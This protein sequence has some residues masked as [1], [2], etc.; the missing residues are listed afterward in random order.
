AEDGEIY[1]ENEIKRIGKRACE[2]A[3]NRNKKL[4]GV[5]KAN[6][7]ES[8]ILWRSIMEDLAKEFEDVELSHMYVDKAAMQ[9]VKDPSQFDVIVTNNIFGDIISDEAAMITG[10][11]G[12]L[13]SASLREAS[14][15]M[16]ERIHGSAPDIAG[17][18]IVT[19][20]ATSTSVS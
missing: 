3:R 14:F 10:S 18:A 9:V 8:S 13:P 1:N 4:R 7:L 11:L 19:Q 6:V 5:D 16:Y 15:G 20:N 2:I 17:Q 12:M